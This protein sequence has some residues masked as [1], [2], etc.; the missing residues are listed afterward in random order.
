MET[1]K[2]IYAVV[3][4]DGFGNARSNLTHVYSAHADMTTATQTA[5][6][7]SRNGFM[8]ISGSGKDGFAVGQP[9]WLDSIRRVYRVVA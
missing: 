2:N 4:A 8:V 5:R 3:D 9:I 7:R 1:N 6:R